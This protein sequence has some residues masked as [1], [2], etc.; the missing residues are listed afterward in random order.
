MNPNNK[1]TFLGCLP[2]Y[3]MNVYNKRI[4]KVEC[5]KHFCRLRLH[6]TLTDGLRC[7]IVCDSNIDLQEGQKDINIYEYG[8]VKYEREVTSPYEFPY[9]E[10][11]LF[12]VKIKRT[13]ILGPPEPD[14][15]VK[16]KE[17]EEILKSLK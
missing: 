11:F 7:F 8:I 6:V 14:Y 13:P 16:I 15:K 4:V 2:E 3:M 5:E 9:K 1:T 12:V 17:I 10:T